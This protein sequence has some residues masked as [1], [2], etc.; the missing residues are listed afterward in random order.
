MRRGY[1]FELVEANEPA[2][3]PGEEWKEWGKHKISN[4]GRVT[5]SHGVVKTP[6][7]RADG[8]AFVEI[9]RKTMLIHRLVAELFLPP[10]L[11]GQTQVVHINGKGNEWWNLRW[12]T[13]SQ[14]ILH[15]H[16]DPKRKSSA[17]MSSKKVQVRKAGT[18]DWRCFASASAAARELRIN[19]GS[20][21][22]CCKDNARVREA[23][24]QNA[25]Q[26]PSQM[27][28]TAARHR[29]LK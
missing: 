3:L 17:P 15:A 4:I 12:A 11:A 29:Q 7:P 8:Y 21:S 25:C 20:I 2:L 22:R 28:E 16:K 9:S 24:T 23:Q 1:N 27:A 18:E 6:I 14:N 19:I 5:D 13:P 26:L 10:P